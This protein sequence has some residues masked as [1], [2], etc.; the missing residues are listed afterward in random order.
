V[1]VDVEWV[2][3]LKPLPQLLPAIGVR[4]LA[5]LIKL[6]ALAQLFSINNN[7]NNYGRTT[8]L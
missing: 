1:G 2:L 6:V 4:V 8:N 3:W 7:N 5:G